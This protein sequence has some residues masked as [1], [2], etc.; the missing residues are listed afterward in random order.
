MNFLKK[1]IIYAVIFT[2]ACDKIIS[3]NMLF[4]R[5]KQKMSREMLDEL[6]M[7]NYLNM[8]EMKAKHPN[9]L[10][11]R[12]KNILASIIIDLVDKENQIK[13]RNTVYWYSRQG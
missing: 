8:L 2:I 6:M 4:N 3:I 1:L 13:Q 12:D 5:N 10:T 11:K 7:D 9:G